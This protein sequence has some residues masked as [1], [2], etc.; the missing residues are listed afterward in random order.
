M[1]I[2]VKEAAYNCKPEKPDP[3]YAR[4]LQEL[5]GGQWGEISVMLGYLFQAWNSR[6]PIK[7]RDMTFDIGT[8]EI[9]HV[10][11]LATM[12]ARLLESSPVEAQEHGAK[13][14][15][16]GAVLVAP[17]SQGRLQA[18]RLYNMT[19]DPGVKDML[20][21]LIARDTM[22]QNQWIAAIAELE[23]DGLEMHPCPSNFPQDLEKSDVTGLFLNHSEG[24]ES[25]A[26]RWAHGPRPDGQ[27]SFEFVETPQPW[28]PEPELGQVDPRL[29][30]T[31]RMPVP[32]AAS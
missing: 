27:G 4:Q 21:Y 26:G 8:E 1:F 31:P 19:D 30:G 13:D 20:S 12:V 14:S 32:K 22:H 18:A 3:V 11:M 16:V 28:G 9:G 7:Y 23:E 10:E 15:I 25:A 24:T 2:R 17:E 29:Y 6:A 5:I